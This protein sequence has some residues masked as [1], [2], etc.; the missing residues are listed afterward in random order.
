MKDQKNIFMWKAGL[1][2]LQLLPFAPMIEEDE[3]Y[4]RWDKQYDISF[5]ARNGYKKVKG[6]WAEVLQ[7]KKVKL[8]FLS[9]R[10]YDDMYALCGPDGDAVFSFHMELGKIVPTIIGH[11]RIPRKYLAE[12]VKRENEMYEAYNVWAEE[13]NK[14]IRA[15]NMKIFVAKW[16]K[17]RASDN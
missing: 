7:D 9:R 11:K 14:E 6:V 17:L 5:D 13:Q 1:N 2:I 12:G 15:E 8:A 4:E 3:M 16:G 10:L